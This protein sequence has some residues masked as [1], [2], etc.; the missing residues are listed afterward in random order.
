MLQ[1][2]TRDQPKPPT[3]RYWLYPKNMPVR[4]YQFDMARA[5]LAANTLV[6]LPTGLGKTFIGAVVVLNYYR[7]FQEVRAP[8]VFVCTA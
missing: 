2:T 7:W 1:H 4:P 6:A 8:C 5:A 3:A